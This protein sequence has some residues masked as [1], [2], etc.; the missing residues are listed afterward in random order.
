MDEQNTWSPYDEIDPDLQEPPENEK[1]AEH[2]RYGV[3]R[4][5]RAAYLNSP[6]ATE[7]PPK[8]GG[9]TFDDITSER[10]E[11]WLLMADAA[12]TECFKDIG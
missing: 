7:N 12:I 3:A 2:I 10:Q 4:V 11:K 5:L 1:P 8:T 9:K 6:E